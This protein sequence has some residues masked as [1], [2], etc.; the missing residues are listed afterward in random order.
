MSI[1]SLIRK[2][3]DVGESSL[4]NRISHWIHQFRVLYM[5]AAY[6]DQVHFWWI[7]DAL[8]LQLTMI[9]CC[10]LTHI[11]LNTSISLDFSHI[12]ND[13]QTLSLF[14][15]FFLKQNESS[16]SHCDTVEHFS[17]FN[18]LTNVPK[19]K[20]SRS[21]G[22]VKCQAGANLELYSLGSRNPT[23]HF[24]KRNSA[25]TQAWYLSIAKSRSHQ[26]L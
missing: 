5:G 2:M 17:F 4:R 9:R 16:C 19:Y 13:E 15:S 12:H 24:S 11:S 8:L 21:A 18:P 20:W 6:D 7:W 22:V 14:F 26:E 23:R 10:N 3:Q 25:F 1:S